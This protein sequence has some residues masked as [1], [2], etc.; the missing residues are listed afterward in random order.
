MPTATISDTGMRGFLKWARQEYP[1]PIYQKIAQGIQTRIPRAFD[2]YMLGG[3]RQ[4]AQRTG[5]A[6][7][8]TATVDTADAANSTPGSPAWGDLISQIIGTATGAYLDVQQQQQQQKV[9]DA[10]LQN[11]QNG[12]P[13]APISL[14]QA[15]ITFGSAGTAVSGVLVFGVLAFLGAKAL[16]IIK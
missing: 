16:G 7:A 8:S 15:G 3:W 10:Q 6:D 2:G 14:S 5:L 11:M 1:A 4:T 12:K 9:I 13:P